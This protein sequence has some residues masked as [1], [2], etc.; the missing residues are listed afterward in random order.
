MPPLFTPGISTLKIWDFVLLLAGH[1]Y[2]RI[3]LSATVGLSA[4]IG[5]S[6]LT[7][8]GQVR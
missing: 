4:A 2:Y 6:L 5:L 3:G 1:T 7:S 8:G